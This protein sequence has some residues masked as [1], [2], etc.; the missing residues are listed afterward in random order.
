[1]MKT[2]KTPSK[3]ELGQASIWAIARIRSQFFYKYYLPSSAAEL[4]P[5]VAFEPVP[6]FHQPSS[7]SV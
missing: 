1:M 2:K 6:K 4:F 3:Y 7:G 5:K